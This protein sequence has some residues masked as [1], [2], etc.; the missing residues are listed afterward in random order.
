MGMVQRQS[1][2]VNAVGRARNDGRW[3]K[4][5]RRLLCKWS[6]EPWDSG[7]KAVLGRGSNQAEGEGILCWD[8][9]AWLRIE[10]SR[11]LAGGVVF[12]A[13]V[14]VCVCVGKKIERIG[15]R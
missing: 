15:E 14:C 7:T 12:R 8:G 10:G 6:T 11:W 9:A 1:L 13:C 4:R 2:H 5:A 3:S